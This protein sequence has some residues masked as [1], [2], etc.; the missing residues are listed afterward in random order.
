[1]SYLSFLP[2]LVLVYVVSLD[3]NVSDLLYLKLISEPIL[4]IKIAFFKYWLW[5]RLRYDLFLLKKGIIPKRFMDMAKEIRN[6]D[7]P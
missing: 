6:P 4:R 2:V 5:F 3:R 1:M 7:Q